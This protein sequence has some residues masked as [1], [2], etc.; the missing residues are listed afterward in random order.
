MDCTATAP[1]A[2]ASTFSGVPLEDWSAL[3]MELTDQHGMSRRQVAAYCVCGAT[4]INDL[5]SGDTKDPG[6][7][8]GEALRALRNLKRKAA[9][10]KGVEPTAPAND[11]GLAGSARATG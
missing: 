4:T 6:H 2:G 7:R 8:I 11:A 1:A 10:E 9:A 3:V 5:A